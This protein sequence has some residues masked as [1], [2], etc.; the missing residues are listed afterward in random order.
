[1]FDAANDNI[2]FYPCPQCKLN[3]LEDTD[4]IN[5]DKCFNWYHFTCS[6][7]TKKEFNVFCNN[8]NKK[9]ICSLCLTKNSCHHCGKSYNNRSLRVNCVNCENTFCSKCVP[10]V[11]GKNIRHF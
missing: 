4:C 1:M 9:F 3:C 5:C 7:L 11:Q 8:I 10:L 6:K 2:Q